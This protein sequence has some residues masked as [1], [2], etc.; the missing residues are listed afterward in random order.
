MRSLQAA[1]RLRWGSEQHKSERD[2]AAIT[3]PLGGKMPGLQGLPA[4]AGACTVTV[5]FC[6]PFP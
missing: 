4:M 5:G 6:L 1:R 3:V 2:T